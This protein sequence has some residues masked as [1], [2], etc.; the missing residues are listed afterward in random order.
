[1]LPTFLIYLTYD[2]SPHLLEFS[3]SN[4]YSPVAKLVVDSYISHMQRMQVTTFLLFQ[5]THLGCQIS[6]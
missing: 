3:V 4:G 5:T 1:M 6:F 2:A